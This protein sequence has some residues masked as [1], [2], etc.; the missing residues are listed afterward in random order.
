MRALDIAT[1]L[2]ADGIDVAVLHV[3]TLKPLDVDAIIEQ[4]EQGGRLVVTAENHSEVGG[5]RDAVCAEFGRAGVSATVRQIALPDDFLAAGS[6]PV[7]DRYGLSKS[8]MLTAVK[9]WL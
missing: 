1:E 8:S 6:R 5:L 9:S 2:E 4:A 7:Q 3:P